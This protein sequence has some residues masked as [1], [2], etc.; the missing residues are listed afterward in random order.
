[1]SALALVGWSAAAVL[2]VL[3][4]VVS[5]LAPGPR[6]E[7]IEWLAAT[8]MYVALLSLFTNLVLRARA[9]ENSL[10]LVAFGLL[11]LVFA[12]GLLV[13]LANALR[14]GH[15]GAKAPTGATH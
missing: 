8:S 14:S 12:G 4:L 15:G 10:G 9:A 2:V 11:W 1:M 3:W 5:S 7:R 13:A 6:R